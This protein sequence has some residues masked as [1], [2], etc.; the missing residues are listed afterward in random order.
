MKL[1]NSLLWQQEMILKN[2][3]VLDT[4]FLGLTTN[5]TKELNAAYNPSMLYELTIFKL[6]YIKKLWKKIQRNNFLLK[7]FKKRLF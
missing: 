5:I 1:D 2:N 3:Y 7:I 6:F 4:R